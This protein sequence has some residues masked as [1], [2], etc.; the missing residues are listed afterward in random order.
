[1]FDLDK[2]NECDLNFVEILHGPELKVDSVQKFCSSKADLV[3]LPKGHDMTFR[4]FAAPS[5]LEG[6][7]TG[8]ASVVAVVT[9]LR[10]KNGEP[11]GRR[12]EPTRCLHGQ[13][14]RGIVCDGA[15]LPWCRI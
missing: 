4:Y 5:T 1:M 7:R 15:E 11:Q 6:L 10:D 2:P 12:V 14:R 13:T 3:S 8:T 9:E